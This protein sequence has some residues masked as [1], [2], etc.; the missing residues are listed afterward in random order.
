MLRTTYEDPGLHDRW[1]S[2]YRN[3][4]RLDHL[5]DRIMDRIIHYVTPPAGALFLDAG[6][7][8]GDHS[9]RIAQRGYRCF[10]VDISEMVL[11]RAEKK[12]Q[13]R[14]LDSKVHLSCQALE[15]LSFAENTF[16]CVHCRGVL[17]HIP[18][19]QAALAS[20]CRVLKPA[21]KIVIVE[22]SKASLD[23]VVV[24]LVRLVMKRQSR[25]VETAGGL[26]F[27]SEVN[28]LPFLVRIANINYLVRR[29]NALGVRHKKTFTTE[30]LGI[31][32]VPAGILRHSVIAS[33]RLCFALHFPS[34]LSNGVALIGEKLPLLSS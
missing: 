3:D 5:N 10:S 22:G 18:D 30:F 1:Q 23:A 7:G 33:N 4:P 16:D 6:C 17:M 8:T 20:L 28:G 29:L 11:R 25:L 9:I 19:W 21:G 27:W 2:I 13:Q 31:G 15:N 14:A 26:E 32:R 12:I 24:R 34:F